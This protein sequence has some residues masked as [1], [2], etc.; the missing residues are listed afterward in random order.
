MNEQLSYIIFAQ[1]LIVDKGFH[2]AHWIFT[3]ASTAD[4][5][6]AIIIF[7]LQMRKLRFLNLRVKRIVMC[8]KLLFNLVPFVLFF[9]FIFINLGDR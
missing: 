5:E 6:E 4:R 8:K 3:I 9:I 7:T 2:L 1:H